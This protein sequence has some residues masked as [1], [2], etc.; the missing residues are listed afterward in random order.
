MNI[1]KIFLSLSSQTWEKVAQVSACVEQKAH[2][3]ASR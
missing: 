1:R 2:G 3:A